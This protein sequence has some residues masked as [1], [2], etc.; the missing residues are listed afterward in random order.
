MQSTNL[1]GVTSSSRV[2]PKPRLQDGICTHYDTKPNELQ[3]AQFRLH[4]GLSAW[5]ANQ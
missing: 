4:M 5:R 1:Q 2:V 3:A